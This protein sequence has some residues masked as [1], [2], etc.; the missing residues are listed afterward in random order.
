[1][2]H[3]FIAAALCSLVVLAGCKHFGQVYAGR[4]SAVATQGG[5]TV[6]YF[7]F[8]IAALPGRMVVLFTLPERYVAEV[9]RSEVTGSLVLPYGH[10]RYLVLDTYHVEDRFFSGFTFE[11][12]QRQYDV[13]A[14]RSDRKN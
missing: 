7:Q 1:M 4:W 10:G 5:S 13:V 3:L 9:G 11:Y 2:K 8:T 6:Q 12:G 14:V